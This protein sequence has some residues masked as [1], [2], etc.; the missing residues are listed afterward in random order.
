LGLVRK[1]S[2]LREGRE[3][4]GDTGYFTPLDCRKK[5]GTL[6]TECCKVMTFVVTP[7]DGQF[8]QY[9]NFYAARGGNLELLTRNSF[10]VVVPSICPHVSDQG[11]DLGKNKPELCKKYD[12]RIDTFL[13]NGKY[14]E[15]D[16]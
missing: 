1:L 3:M 5:D 2:F 10:A 12:C 14:K 7:P 4:S 11:C 6:C 9:V 16:L 13:T 15:G 8:A